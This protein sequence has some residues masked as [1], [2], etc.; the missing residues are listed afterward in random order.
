MRHDISIS[1]YYGAPSHSCT[2]GYLTVGIA[3]SSEQ[4]VAGAVAAKVG[5][6]RYGF[7]RT[8]QGCVAPLASTTHEKKQEQTLILESN[9]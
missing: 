5:L 8:R 1:I 7:L 3:F 9:K 6:R 2:C 4:Q